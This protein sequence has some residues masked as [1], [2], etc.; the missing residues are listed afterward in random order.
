VIDRAVQDMA[1]QLGA[2]ERAYAQSGD[3]LAG[4]SVSFADLFVAP[5][6]AYVEAFPEGANL[7]S[8]MPNIRRAQGVMRQ[9]ESFTTTQP[10]QGK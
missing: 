8:D 3:F 4:S 2:L 10:P 6:L 1:P 7:L 9:R 5:I